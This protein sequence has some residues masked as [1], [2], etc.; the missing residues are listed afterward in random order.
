MQMPRD[1][2]P[3]DWSPP[4]VEFLN[5]S[6]KVPP[7]RRRPLEDLEMDLPDSDQKVELASLEE[8][9]WNMSGPSQ[10]QAGTPEVSK[11]AAILVSPHWPLLSVTQANPFC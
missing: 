11:P 2:F 4:P 1:S 9:F 8:L 3:T 5:K 10:Q 6:K 7:A